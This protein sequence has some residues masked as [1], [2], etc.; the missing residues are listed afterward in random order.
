M[1]RRRHFV[2]AATTVSLTIVACLVLAEIVLRFFPVNFGTRPEAVTADQPVYHFTPNLH[3]V[4]SRNWNFELV[5]YGRINNFGWVNDQDYRKEDPTP[6]LAV[7]GDSYIEALMVPYPKTVHGRLAQALDGKLRVYSFAASGAPLSQYVIWARHAVREFGSQALLINVV[8]NDFDESHIAYSLDWRGYWVYAPGPDAQLQ[9][10]LLQY[11]PGLF[12]PVVHSALARYLFLNLGVLKL[13]YDVRNWLFGRPAM[14]AP[15]YAGHTLA[16]TDPTRMRDSLAVIDAFFHDFAEQ[17][18][19]PPGRVLFTMDGFRYPAAA[20]EGAG[21]YFD[22]MR[23]AFQR[24]AR[25]LGYE[26]I[27]LDPSFFSHYA[28]HAE[29]FDFPTDGHWNATAH[30][31]AAEEILA[32]KLIAE[33]IHQP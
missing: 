25:S 28:K 12:R 31:I 30:G 6:L 5:N 18:G 7:I 9:L 8:G 32:S 16:S 21:T 33:L 26:V 15:L 23:Q 24:K 19:L 14:A 17:V 27:D 10:R 2:F 20:E 29:P 11:H 3:Y 4:Y 1:T 13:W 22:L